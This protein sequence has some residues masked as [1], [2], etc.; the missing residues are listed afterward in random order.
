MKVTHYLI[1]N[2]MVKKLIKYNLKQIK[3][4]TILDPFYEILFWFFKYYE[5]YY[6]KICWKVLDSYSKVGRFDLIKKQIPN[7]LAKMQIISD[8]QMRSK[9][10]Y[11]PPLMNHRHSLQCY[12]LI[13]LSTTNAWK[14]NNQILG[15]IFWSIMS[16]RWRQ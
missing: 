12:S 16:C 9:D 15:R 10:K 4:W 7:L 3:R 1:L 11:C 14:I 5:Y 2:I 6:Q 8:N 13:A